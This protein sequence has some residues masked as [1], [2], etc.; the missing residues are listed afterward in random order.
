MSGVEARSV[1]LLKEV[2][3]QMVYRFGRYVIP[4]ELA[5]TIKEYIEPKPKNRVSPGRK[6]SDDEAIEIR[7]KRKKGDS[8]SELAKQYGV[9]TPTILNLVEYRSYK[10]R[11]DKTPW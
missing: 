1:R 9:S 5:L 2:Y 11:K 3:S 10:V 8:I 4:A 7:N 6:F